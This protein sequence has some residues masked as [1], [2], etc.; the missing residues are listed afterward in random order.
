MSAGRQARMGRV[1]ATTGYGFAED[2]A[3]SELGIREEKRLHAGVFHHTAFRA[4]A[5]HAAGKIG[6]ALE[7]GLPQHDRGLRGASAGP[8]DRH[9]RAFLGKFA[10]AP[11]QFAE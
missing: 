9:N 5:Q 7:S 3:G 4:P 10:G 1:S 6:H 8:A 11:G 2:T